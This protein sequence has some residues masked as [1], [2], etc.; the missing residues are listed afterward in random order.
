MAKRLLDIVGAALGLLVLAPLLAAIAL[1]VRCDS[2]GPVL[3]RQIR[4]G[5]GRREFRMLKF[6]TMR[7]QDP[8]GV[9]Q[10]RERPP[11]SAAD[12]RITRAGRVLRRY[13]IDEL[14][15]LWNVLRGDMSLV[16]PRP[17]MPEQLA[18][19]AAQYE[20]RFDVHSGITGL[21]QITGRQSLDWPEKLRLDAVYA[22]E[23]T[24]LTDIRILARTVLVVAGGRGLYYA[25]EG[26]SWRAHLLQQP[27]L[28]R[29]R[30]PDSQEQS[31]CNRRRREND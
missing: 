4:V 10:L 30:V 21:A 1:W 11:S 19:V 18:A 6:R 28:R 27:E 2:P 24:F 5:R 7:H 15:Q 31:A 22:R 12:P 26:T 23:G 3:F 29:R 20:S 13:S 9:D 14:P 8:A 17:L 16:G 25:A